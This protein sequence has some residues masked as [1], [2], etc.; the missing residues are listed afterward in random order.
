MKVKD[1]IARLKT[2]SMSKA[3]AIILMT[4]SDI[5]RQKIKHCF[6]E[7]LKQDLPLKNGETKSFRYFRCSKTSELAG[8]GGAYFP[9]WRKWQAAQSQPAMPKYVVCNAD[10]GE[11]GT[12]KDR[13][14]MNACPET[15]IEGMI[16]CGY[17]IGASHGIIY[18]R[19]EYRWLLHK[20]EDAI[21][22]MKNTVFSAKTVAILRGLTLIS[23]FRWER[24]LMFVVKKRHYW[25][26]SRANAAN[27]GLNGFPCRK[28]ILAET[29]SSQQC[30]NLLCRD[31][32]YRYW[33]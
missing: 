4:T 6:S 13:V 22:N 5:H 33:Y 11:P 7:S 24:V 27:Q 23:G 21:K 19:G 10:E 31:P 15:L 29:N 20:L 28:R 26:L 30:G 8:R 2:V 25:N 18:L 3:Y 1:I 9:T 14:L 17:T 16:V 32:H 12:F